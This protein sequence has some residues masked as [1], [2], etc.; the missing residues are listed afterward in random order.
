MWAH[1][2]TT[3]LCLGRV[4]CQ[5]HPMRMTIDMCFATALYLKL[6]SS[7]VHSMCGHTDARQQV[8][9]GSLFEQFVARAAGHYDTPTAEHLQ[10]AAAIV[11]K[12]LLRNTFLALQTRL[13]FTP[14]LGSCLEEEQFALCSA[15]REW[16]YCAVGLGGA[17]GSGLPAGAVKH[18]NNS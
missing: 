8:K 15:L 18:V 16:N 10:V 12:S 5:T 11:A 7:Q 14:V 4:S 17:A 9:Y 13:A 2:V 3:A 6:P 1:V